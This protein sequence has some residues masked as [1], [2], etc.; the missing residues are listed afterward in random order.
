QRREI[1]ETH[2]RDLENRQ[3]E[4]QRSLE[5]AEQALRQ[6]QEQGPMPARRVETRERPQPRT[7]VRDQPTPRDG[8][9]REPIRERDGRWNA[10]QQNLQAM[11]RE[12][13]DLQQQVRG[14]REEIG[15]QGVEQRGIEQQRAEVLRQQEELRNQARRMEEQLN[16]LRERAGADAEG[17]GRAIEDMRNDL[18]RMGKVLGRVEQERL[19]A[20]GDIKNEVQKLRERVYQLRNDLVK[21]QGAVD[22]LLS[23]CD[24]STVG[25]AGFVWGW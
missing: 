9:M 13:A 25:S 4:L 20:Q 21:M 2:I 16:G 14:T 15:R 8:Q 17:Y 22:M 19:G 11:Q 5:A 24:R 6:V 7:E 23:E 18:Q 10:I 3:R 12:I 1:V